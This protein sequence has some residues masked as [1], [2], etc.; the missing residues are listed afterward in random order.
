M[1]KAVKS[2]DEINCYRS[3]DLARAKFCP[4]VF[5]EMFMPASDHSLCA[6]FNDTSLTHDCDNAV[7]TKSHC[8]CSSLTSSFYAGCPEGAYRVLKRVDFFFFSS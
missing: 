5:G 1:W 7:L 8:S 4:P 2:L 3:D 6:Q